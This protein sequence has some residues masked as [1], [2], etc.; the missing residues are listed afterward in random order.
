MKNVLV[1]VLALSVVACVTHPKTRE[2]FVAR[3]A[4]GA[5]GSLVVSSTTTRSYDRVVADLNK[6][7]GECLNY[8]RIGTENTGAGW[9]TTQSYY[10]GS[11]RSVGPN[12]TEFTFRITETGKP[13][14]GPDDGLF[15]AATDVTRLGKNKT[16]VVTYT[17]SLW[18]HPALAD[19]IKKWSEGKPAACP[20]VR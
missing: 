11:G 13:P 9:K 4:E 12:K 16:K 17:T 15:R 5:M 20:N 14:T 1:F 7:F 3:T 19:A 10:H 8:S 2:E 18:G 6:K